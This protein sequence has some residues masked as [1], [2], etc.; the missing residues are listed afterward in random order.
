MHNVVS[1]RTGEPKPEPLEIREYRFQFNGDVY[2]VRRATDR[3]TGGGILTISDEDSRP[4][5]VRGASIPG[6]FVPDLIH[7]WSAGRTKGRFEGRNS[8]R[9]DLAELLKPEL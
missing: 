8:L 4:V 1:I 7:A 3:D 9:A 5:L 6:E 2:N